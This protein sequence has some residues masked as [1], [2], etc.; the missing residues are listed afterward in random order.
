MLVSRP[1]FPKPKL[2]RRGYDT[3]EVDGF[4]DLIIAKLKGRPEGDAVTEKD[5]GIMIFRDGR[6]SSA[7]DSDAVDDW[8]ARIRPKLKSIDVQVR[9]QDL[10]TDRPGSVVDMAAAPHFAD[11]FPRVS[12]AVLGFAI[13]DVDSAMDTLRSQL[14][15]NVAPSGEQIM[16]LSFREQSGGYRQ[17]AVAQALELIALAREAH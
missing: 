16:A 6:G 5:L 3:A 1:D 13:E 17:I 8:I 2:G 11:R 12:R 15:G 9:E 10:P 7:Y 14:S 4:V